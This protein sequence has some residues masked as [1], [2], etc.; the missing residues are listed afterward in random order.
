MTNGDLVEV[1]EDLYKFLNWFTWRPMSNKINQ[2][3]PVTKANGGTAMMHRMIIEVTT[4][5]KIE[6]GFEVD[7]IDG[8]KLNNRKENLRVCTPYENG[9]NHGIHSTM[10]KTGFIGVTNMNGKSLNPYRAILTLP[11]KHVQIGC[12]D[13]AENAAFHRDLAALKYKG[14][15]A[16]LNF[17]DKREKYQKILDGG[18]NPIKSRQ[19]SSYYHGVTIEPNGTWRAQIVINKKPRRLGVFDNEIDAAKA[20]DNAIIKF[21]HDRK[22][23]N[24][25]SG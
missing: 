16:R 11:D 3:Y 9:Q 1:D 13:T 2:N 22:K 5:R 24:F 23:L 8:D 17:E 12:F 25:P 20:Y 14:E 4:G 6:K 7:H 21:G 15:Y 18:Y 10:N 19:K